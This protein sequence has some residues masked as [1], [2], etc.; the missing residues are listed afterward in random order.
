MPKYNLLEYNNNSSV[1]S[2]SLWNYY[3]DEI[4][5]SAI[6]N[7]DDGNKINNNKTITSKCFEYKTK[8]MRW[9]PDDNNTLNTEIVVSLKYV[10]NFWRFFNL[11][12]INCE[13]KLESLW[14]K[15]CIISEIS[16][17]LVVPGNPDANSPVVAMAAIQT[18]R[19]AIQLNNAKLYLPNVTLSINDKIKFLENI[20]KTLKKTISW[21]KYRSKV[22]TQTK[23]II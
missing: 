22:T 1:T 8:I 11:P 18:T 10:S 17:T 9:T 5:D 23:T 4:N 2:E 16:I 6:E 15:K 14:S 12:L 7:N 21:N 13:I 20:K 19:A 3:R